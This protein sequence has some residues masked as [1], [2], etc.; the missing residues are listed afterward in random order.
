[1]SPEYPCFPT[2]RDDLYDD[3]EPEREPDE[4][5]QLEH[6]ERLLAS[7]RWCATSGQRKHRLTGVPEI[8]RVR[9]EAEALRE[10][11]GL[12]EE[13][14]EREAREAAQTAYDM[15][16]DAAVDAAKER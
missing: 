16:V 3:E 5:E 2:H 10:A 15:H 14:E 7:P 12:E 4:E 8:D 1:M 9:A 6:L 13:D 11:L